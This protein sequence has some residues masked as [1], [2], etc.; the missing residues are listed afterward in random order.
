MKHIKHYAIILSCLLSIGCVSTTNMGTTG[1]ERKQFTMIPEKSFTSKSERSYN[2]FVEKQKDNQVLVKDPKLTKVLTNLSSQTD[3]YRTSSKK[4]KWEING[5]LNGDLNAYGF[6]GGKIIINTG[7]YWK[8]NLTEDELAFVIAHEMA[9][10]LRDHSREKASML[11]AGNVAMLTASAGLGVVAS[12]ATTV[13]TQSAYIPKAWLH[14]A[15]ADS[16]G[17]EIMA[18]SGYNPDAALTFWEKFQ[19]ESDRR[20]QYNVK[21]A[22]S[23]EIYTQRVENIKRLLPTMQEK[24]FEVLERK[25]NTS[26]SAS[27]VS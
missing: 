6:P 27:K 7:L 14:E 20:K 13:S 8:L 22:M 17:L 10:A 19:K 9:H 15:E 18:R 23:D 25:E 5:N 3:I 12:V 2:K 1:A 26:S 21:P 4:W 24:Y 16:L 11:L